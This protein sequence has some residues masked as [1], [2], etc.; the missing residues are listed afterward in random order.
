MKE[1]KIP[2]GLKTCLL[3]I[4]FHVGTITMGKVVADLV[5]VVI[6]SQNRRAR[7]AR[8][9]E[10]VMQQ[11]WPNI[12]IIIVDD[13]STDDT[14]HFLEK[15]K[16][17]SRIPIKTFRNVVALGGAG[18]R[19]KGIELAKG[20]Y[21]AFL[22]DDDMWMQEK[23]SSQIGM[24]KKNQS[25]SSVS[26]SFLVQYPS[27]KQMLKQVSPPKN[28]Q[29]LLHTNHLG[30]ASMCLTTRQMLLDIGGFDEGLRSGQDW[31]LWVK[32]NDLGKVLVCREPLVQYFFHQGVSITGNP[33]SRYLGRRRF[34]LR[35]KKRMSDEIKKHHLSELLFCRKVL[36]EHHR[37]Q[38]FFGFLKVAHLVGL[39]RSFRYLYRYLKYSLTQ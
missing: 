4:V 28:T 2:L 7:L 22:D 34:Y 15:L 33:Y 32:L 10:S 18:A 19:N 36:L 3:F 12:E 8:A 27:G 14:P 13:A 29:Q 37:M 23:L 5:S 25:A 20:Q 21:V 38:R 30:G 26:C 11:T 24:M 9:I 31:D 1:V 35:Y 16:S 39:L 17:T 6:P